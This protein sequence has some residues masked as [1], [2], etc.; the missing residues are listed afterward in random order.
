MAFIIETVDAFN[1]LKDMRKH[2]HP[3]GISIRGWLEK[4][5]P[6][7]VEFE[8]PTI[9][10]VNGQP[11]LRSDW[12]RVI[13]KGDTVNFIRCVGVTW[14][15]I[16]I[17]VI[18]LALSIYIAVTTKAPE[19][20]GELPGSSPVFSTA[21]KINAVRL[22]EPIECSYGRNRVYPSLASR[23]FFRY[24]GNDQFQHAL[25]CIGQGSYDIEQINIGDTDIDDFEEAEYQII[26]PGGV[27]TLFSTNVITSIEVG[28]QTLYAPNQPEYV[29]PG[30][31]GPFPANPPGTVCKRLEVDLVFPRGIYRTDKKGRLLARSVVLEI[32]YRRI[33]DTGAPLTSYQNM[34]G[35][36]TR[37]TNSPLRLTL[38][39]DATPGRYEIRARRTNNR[40][41]PSTGGDQAVWEGMR[42]FME[43]DEPTYG[44]V[45]L[46]AVKIRATNN[47]NNRTTE[48]YNVICTRKLPIYESGGFSAPVATRS[49]V[50]AM[51]DVFRAAY[52]GRVTSDAFFDLDALQDLDD[53]YTSRG[54]YFDW[55]FRDPITVW[56]AAR[57]IARVG[58]ATPLLSG[59]L[60]TMRRDGPL[61][62]PVTMFIPE[63]M[64][65][66]TF[67]LDIKLWEVNEFDSVSIEY[68]DPDTGYQQ[69]NVLCTL[70]GGTTLNPEDIRIAGCQDRAHAYREGL[71]ILAS[72]FYLRENI[73]FETGLEGM[74]PSYGDLVAVSH[75]VPR[76]AQS[77][78]VVAVD[79]LPSNV[80]RLHVSEPLRFEESATYK[81][82]LR[83][84]DGSLM[85]PYVATEEVNPKQVLVTIVGVVDFL[86]GGTTEPMLFL[87]GIIEQ[88]V[89]YGK[90][91]KMEPQGGER[92]RITLVNYAPEIHTFDDEEPEPLP[93]TSFPNDPDLP[94][95]TGLKLEHVVTPP[96]QVVIAASW[97]AIIFA[98][99]YMV[100][101]SYDDGDSWTLAGYN[102]LPNLTF[103][104]APG[105]ILVR[106][107]AI[108]LGQ[109]PWDYEEITIS[110]VQGLVNDIPWVG[111][112]WGAYWWGDADI[113]TWR[114]KVFDTEPSAPV[115]LLSTD[116]T[117]LRYDFT[118]PGY[119]QVHLVEM[120]TNLTLSGGGVVIDGVTT[121]RGD[122][123]LVGAQ[124]DPKE[125]G[126]WVVNPNGGWTRYSQWDSTG[127]FAPS[128]SIVSRMGTT[129]ANKRYLMTVPGGFVLG[130]NDITVT[131]AAPYNLTRNHRMELDAMV[132]DDETLILEPMELPSSLDLENAI[133][134]APIH[135]DNVC[136]GVTGLN[137]VDY[138]LTW[139]NPVD[140]DVI[141]CR[142]FSG[143]S[144]GFYVPGVSIA[145]YSFTF[146][147]GD[148]I[149]E[150]I[151]EVF[152]PGGVQAATIYWVV[153]LYDVWGNETVISAEDIML[154]FP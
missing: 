30:W 154:P 60:I 101:F 14:V 65:K 35:T 115:E 110:P 39:H 114:V 9:C 37:K 66:G 127:D 28:G 76:W 73:T 58:R 147:I 89:K 104:A 1:P 128:V 18:A 92:V 93:P 109:G 8:H 7:F 152:A 94:T 70:P 61:T 67:Q 24:V 46:L 121:A 91:V 54:E 96:S 74:I 10:L 136:L 47:L 153:A 5:Y 108:G 139:V 64:L 27:A 117:A 44:D 3:G 148:P 95:V 113:E 150:V 71:F 31:V 90:V 143:S 130:T 144:P 13:E 102:N 132:L 122:V 98:R 131:Y 16:I 120:T 87:F 72:R 53:L 82:L 111:Q 80:Y 21:G 141:I 75:D 33:D 135:L 134:A 107:A 59:S 116:I 145:S 57:T 86:I 41:S 12:T 55:C 19:T 56:D 51:V 79:T 36:I 84:K 68:T 48:K 100:E 97:K 43:G 63:N 125:N 118:Y 137:Q 49:I 140:D 78:Y 142:I 52:G 133:P 77:G 26:Q 50:W 85:G 103:T 20:P 151:Y 138:R 17:V 119:F 40:T 11:V 2:E 124:T 29:D 34:G 106:V 32:M 38:Y 42:A 105:R 88:E 4:E 45:T 23:P 15:I 25:M 146:D 129:N 69:E 149:D 112:S 83:K 126:V 62:V 6:G 81:V 22:G 123:I 99:Y